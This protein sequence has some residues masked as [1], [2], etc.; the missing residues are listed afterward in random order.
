[1]AHGPVLT[2]AFFIIGVAY[3]I[4]I[5]ITGAADISAA[6]GS[7]FPRWLTLLMDYIIAPLFQVVLSPLFYALP[8][9]VYNDLKL[10]REGSDLAA[11]IAAAE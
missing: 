11:R 4:V 8:M 5:I 3:L 1:V 6:A 10:R 9:A 2:I 7:A